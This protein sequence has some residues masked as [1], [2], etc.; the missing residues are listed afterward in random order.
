MSGVPT[1]G[2][3]QHLL[4]DRRLRAEQRISSTCS[5]VRRCRRRARTGCG[6]RAW[7]VCSSWSWAAASVSAAITLTPRSRSGRSSCAEG[8]NRSPVHLRAPRAAPA[9]RSARRTRTAVRARRR[10]GRRT[11]T[12]RGCRAARGCPARGWRARRGSGLAS[13]RKPCSSSTS[14]GKRSAAAG[15][16]RSARLVVWSLPGARPEPEVDPARVQRGE[17]AELLGDHQRRVVGQHD[18][19][20]AEPDRL[21]VGGDV[22]DEHAVADDA[23]DPMLWC[24]AYQTRS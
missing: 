4:D 24:S 3:P 15:S 5:S 22:G 7:R 21:G 23:I 8:S 14:C 1:R 17:R 6:T 18:P 11:A 9:A 20:G 16:R 10:A 13:L 19:A 2:V 12:S